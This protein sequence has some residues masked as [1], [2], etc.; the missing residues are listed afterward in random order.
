M[1]YILALI[2]L[3]TC[4]SVLAVD[5][6]T[7]IPEKAPGVINILKDQIDRVWKDIPSRT[8]LAGLIEQES[9]I[10][11]T[12]SRCF[13]PTSSLK[14]AREEGAG[15]GQ[16]TRAYAK[17][18]S[19][20]FDSLEDMVKRHSAQLKG[21]NW[22]TVYSRPDLQVTAMILMVKD[23][24]NQLDKDIP[25]QER[26]KF[27]D[28]AYN[29][30]LGNLKKDRRTCGL[31]SNCD[32]NIWFKNVE[33]I[34][35]ASLK[36]IYGNRTGWDINREHVSSVFNIRMNKYVPLMEDDSVSVKNTKCIKWSE[37]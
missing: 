18:G 9:C 24:Y 35:P 23:N 30:G 3:L 10:S 19:L 28:S 8:Y 26:L 25:Y 33:R 13:D 20:R 31:K 17:D 12:H 21:L 2:S 11:L 32:P 15:L 5:P 4:S 34:K 14:T 7:Y 29:R 6:Y 22:K 37:E 1:V 36:P 27:T 16:L